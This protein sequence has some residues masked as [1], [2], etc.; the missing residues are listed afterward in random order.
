MRTAGAEPLEPYP[1]SRVG[2]RVRCLTC[3]SE[4]RPHYSSVKRGTGVCRPCGNKVAQYKN[5]EG[6][7][8]ATASR[9]QKFGFEALEEIGNQK[10]LARVRC[11]A[12]GQISRK[13]VQ[14][15]RNLCQCSRARQALPDGQS[16]AEVK[17]EVLRFWDWEK[18]DVEPSQVSRGSNS[19]HFFLCDLGHSYQMA[20]SS[21]TIPGRGCPVCSNRRVLHGFNDLESQAPELARLWHPLRNGAVRPSDLVP[22]SNRKVWWLGPC[23]HEWEASPNKRMS[24]RGCPVCQNLL[25]VPGVND[26]ATTHPSLAAQWHATRNGVLG[27]QSVVWGTHRKV[28]WLGTCGHEWESS[29]VSRAS[30][31]GVGCPYCGGRRILPGFNDVASLPIARH[32][33]FHKNKIAIESLNRGTPR[34]VWWRCDS[35]HSYQMQVN[36]KVKRPLSCPVCSRRVFQ[37]GVNDLATTHPDLLLEWDFDKNSGLDPASVTSGSRTK[38]WWKCDRGH[39]WSQGID[40]RQRFGCPYCSGR[41]PILGETDLATTHPLLAREWHRSRNGKAPSE[42]SFGSEYKAWWS[43]PCGHEWL[44]PVGVRVKGSG[45]PQCA[46]YGYS[47]L[48]PGLLYFVVHPWSAGKIGIT[49]VDA[50]QSRLEALRTVGFEVVEVWQ[51]E[52]GQVIRDLETKALRWVRKDLGLGPYFGSEE[53]GRIGGWTETFSLADLTTEEVCAK[54]TDLLAQ[55]EKSK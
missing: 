34:K 42:V 21:W 52:D 7:R 37:A 48:S 5:R 33:D 10:T 8:T 9:L 19:R 53:M 17:P 50:R 23:G 3:G 39:S 14:D 49:N 43:G 25:L 45:C 12:C 24:G 47:S 18:N 36:L 29:V 41:Y 35:G 38:A 2:W 22:H 32:W 54:I 55:I 31:R 1:G 51:R 4:N 44:Q 27:P 16:L 15:I 11:L 30:A 13:K 6:Y 20:V 40:V 26:L 28:W 46:A